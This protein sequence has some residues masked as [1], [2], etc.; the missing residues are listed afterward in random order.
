[1]RYIFAFLLALFVFSGSIGVD[2]YR[3]YCNMRGE[4]RTFFTSGNDLCELLT[5]TK[6]DSCCSENSSNCGTNEGKDGCCQ[7][8]EL[9]FSIEPDFSETFDQYSFISHS[10]TAIVPHRA[11]IDFTWSFSHPCSEK[12]NK[13]PPPLPFG[14]GLL[15]R[16]DV[17][18]I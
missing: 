14:R 9:T 12:F 7:E 13:P 4:S 10:F 8:D 6:V 17:W 1:M 2:I 16:I 5:E 3:S 18:R 11:G 15:T